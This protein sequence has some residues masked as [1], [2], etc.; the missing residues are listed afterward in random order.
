MKRIFRNG[1]WVRV[2]LD[3]NTDGAGGW[4]S[5]DDGQKSDTGSSDNTSGDD[6]GKKDEGDKKTP[7]N[8]PYDR[9]KE[10]NDANKAMKAKLAEYEKKE[11]EEAEKKKKADEEEA[12]KNGEF[13]K[14]LT[15]KDQE[16]ADYKKQQETWKEREETVKSRNAERVET[17]KKNLGDWWNDYEAL[18][19]DI[20]DPFKL[21]QKLDSIEKIAWSKKSGGSSGGS[22]MP[23]WWK[24]EGRL[25]E[26]QEKARKW[27]HLTNLE[28][29]EYLKLA[30]EK[31]SKEN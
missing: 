18:V 24:N 12:K 2:L 1:R 30:R 26:L 13:E 8:V 20:T 6:S 10:V 9:F 22:N 29:Q 25:A 14:L 27:E 17:L 11:A 16:I 3:A 28:Q 23:S 31:R 19:S 7:D 21:S 4:E 5:G 15:Q